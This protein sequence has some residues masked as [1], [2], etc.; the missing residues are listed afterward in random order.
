MSVDDTAYGGRCDVSD[1]SESALDCR[2]RIDA[3]SVIL[4]R[5]VA[6]R[7]GSASLETVVSNAIFDKH[8]TEGGGDEKAMPSYTVIAVPGLVRAHHNCRTQNVMLDTRLKAVIA[9]ECRAQ[10]DSSHWGLSY[11]T[12]ERVKH[13]TEGGPPP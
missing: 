10:V 3:L 6:A 8:T 12:Q 7:G 13:K 1:Q 2:A 4:S 9:L 5:A 11:P